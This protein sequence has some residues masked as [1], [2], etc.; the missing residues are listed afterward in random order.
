MQ[1]D[2]EQQIDKSQWLPDGEPLITPERAAK[3]DVFTGPDCSDCGAT[4]KDKM[5]KLTCKTCR[6]KGWVGSTNAATIDA[7]DIR[8]AQVRIRDILSYLRTAEII[9]DDQYTDGKTFQAWRD[10]H[11]VALGLERPVSNGMDEPAVLKLR[12]YGFVLL[13]KKLEVNDVKAIN[14]ALD[15][16][17]THG[18]ERDAN[19][20][21]EVYRT[22]FI[23]LSRVII[24]IRE[25]IAYLENASE[26]ERN[27]LACE[28]LKKLLAVI[29]E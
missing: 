29:S 22:A 17:A 5:T 3:G 27:A 16:T 4:G 19:R 18:T 6:G 26:E 28:Q 1:H 9:T 24:P 14:K 20:E 11:R 10:Q 15:L 21:K 23:S 2:A 12:A 25:H 7:A 13:L 8:F